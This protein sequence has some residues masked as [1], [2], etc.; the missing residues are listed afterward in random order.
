MGLSFTRQGE[1]VMYQLGRTCNACNKTRK[2]NLLSYDQQTLSAY[3]NTSYICNENHPNSV[4]NLIKNQ[5]E[6]NLISYDQAKQLFDDSI[7]DQDRSQIN[8]MLNNPITLRLQNA[9]MVKFLIDLQEVTKSKS[10]GNAIRFC[11][12][13]TMKSMNNIDTTVEVVRDE[14]QFQETLQTVEVEEVEDDENKW[15][16]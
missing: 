11:I 5:R 1:C 4:K 3:C 9:D 13:N 10:I 16:F 15:V 14:Q 8:R 12:E 2:S 7:I 6:T